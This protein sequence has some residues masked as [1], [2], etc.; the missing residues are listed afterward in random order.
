MSSG[1]KPRDAH[2]KAGLFP[3]TVI[4]DYDPEK[5]DE[6]DGN[7]FFPMDDLKGA[8]VR[9]SEIVPHAHSSLTDST[10]ASTGDC[11]VASTG[12]SGESMIRHSSD[13]LP[14]RQPA[15]LSLMATE[16][17]NMHRATAKSLDQC[18][19]GVKE[20]R[21]E[22]DELRLRYHAAARR[23]TIETRSWEG[24]VTCYVKVWNEMRRRAR[25]GL[26]Y[27]I[28]FVYN[29]SAV[30]TLERMLICDSF[31]VTRLP[32]KDAE[33]ARLYVAFDVHALSTKC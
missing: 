27:M 28:F 10:I 1:V 5:V 13:V 18:P 11:L 31:T 7:V 22:L 24:V 4:Y 16:S 32:C 33:V 19:M 14:S 9:V 6:T 23:K 2:E 12:D 26:N 20:A 15:H 8:D 30:E 25:I 29:T 21:K 17:V 3:T